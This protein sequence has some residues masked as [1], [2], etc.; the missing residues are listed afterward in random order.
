MPTI[1]LTLTGYYAGRPLCDC[2]KPS[3]LAKGVKFYHAMFAPDVILNDPLLCPTCKRLWDESANDTEEDEAPAE[4]ESDDSLIIYTLPVYWASYLMNGDDSGLEPGE[5]EQVDAFLAKEGLGG[6]L[7]CGQDQW[8]AHSN[9]ATTLGGDVTDYTFARPEEKE[10][11]IAGKAGN[12][13]EDEDRYRDDGSS[14]V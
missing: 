9:D 5:K 4:E 10:D 1:H 7:D 13:S 3:E 11:P 8:F 2:D 14:I 12:I 6:P